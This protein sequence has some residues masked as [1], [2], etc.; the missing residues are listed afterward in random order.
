MYDIN[1]LWVEGKF[2]LVCKKLLVKDNPKKRLSSVK[3]MGAILFRQSREGKYSR[4][5]P[6]RDKDCNKKVKIQSI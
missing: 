4:I 1:S 3:S 6:L 2:S 5:Y